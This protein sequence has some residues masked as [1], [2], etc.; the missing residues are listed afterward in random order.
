MGGMGGSTTTN[1][2]RT[3]VPGIVGGG[4]V[5]KPQDTQALA[6]TLSI[7]TASLAG[8]ASAAVASVAAQ[9]AGNR[10][11][12]TWAAGVGIMGLVFAGLL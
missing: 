7:A 2:T 3:E 1:S 9:G 11:E 10:H 8:S 5:L 6:P 4:D 12:G